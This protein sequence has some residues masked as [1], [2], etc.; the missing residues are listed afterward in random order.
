MFNDSTMERTL[1]RG[2]VASSSVIHL[3]LRE[4]LNQSPIL[5]ICE[6]KLLAKSLKT[7]KLIKENL[8]ES[9]SVAVYWSTTM[10]IGKHSKLKYLEHLKRK[11]FKK[12]W[13]LVKLENF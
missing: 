2:F 12:K 8:A 10:R 7:L 11:C 6:E 9:S 5:F 4:S 1:S 3:D 13:I